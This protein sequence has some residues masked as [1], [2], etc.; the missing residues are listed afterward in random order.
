MNKMNWKWTLVFSAAVI[1]AAVLLD[2][3]AWAGKPVPPTP[4]L[5]NPTEIKYQIQ[6]WEIPDG[7]V[8]A[9]NGTNRWGDSVGDYGL[10]DSP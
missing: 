3:V 9:F 4:P 7:H 8:G 2:A 5:V 6:F 1:G 10:G